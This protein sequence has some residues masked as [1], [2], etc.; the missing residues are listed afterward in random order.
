MT[1]GAPRAIEAF[2]FGPSPGGDQGDRNP[3][4]G[5]NSVPRVQAPARSLS[6]ESWSL[7]WI[8]RLHG[9][10]STER[11]RLSAS[12]HAMVH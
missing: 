2:K 1:Q 12:E 4:S 7:I 10:A 11:K 9:P 5:G 6:S 8:D 3:A